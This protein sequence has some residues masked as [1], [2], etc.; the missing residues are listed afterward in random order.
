MRSVARCPPDGSQGQAQLLLGIVRLL[1]VGQRGD[2]LAVAEE[3]RRL[4]GLADA[5]DTSAPGLGQELG[6]LVLINLG[7]AEFFT[8]RFDR[9]E[10]HLEEGRALAH[11]IGRPYLEFTG[12]AYQASNEFFRSFAHAAAHGQQAIEMARRHGWSDEL[13]A[14]LAYV[15]LGAVLAWQMRLEE[16]GPLIQRAERT[17]R[18]EAQPMAGMDVCCNRAV[19]ELGRGRNAEALAALCAGERLAG[20]L[21]APNPFL[22]V[23][24]ALQVQALVRLGD[25]EGAEQALA[26][27]GDHERGRGELQTALAVLR[28]AHDDP[29]GATAALAPVLDGSAPLLW[30]AAWQ[31]QACLLEAIARDALGDQD[32]AGLALERAL[33]CAEPDGALWWFV[34]HPAPVLLKRLARHRTAHAAL[35]ADILSLLAEGTTPQDPLVPPRLSEPLRDSELRVLRYLPTNLTLPEIARELDVSHNTVKTHIRSLFTKLG[36]HRRAEAVDRAR[37][38]G[39]LAPAPRRH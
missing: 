30:P 19:F 37:T 27:S 5:P 3:V 4:E 23:F 39:L 31:T 8:A 1:V 12:L 2:L 16:A 6:A 20:L 11:R 38:L 13:A 25:V 18:A 34:L 35:I 7:V 15:I 33:D 28:L 29:H 26:G 21:S 36:T 24:R 10:Q 14:G 17:V 22:P 9:A 32:A